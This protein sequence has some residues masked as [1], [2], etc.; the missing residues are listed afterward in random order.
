M[1]EAVARD[2][3]RAPGFWVD[4]LIRAAW[5][6]AGWIGPVQGSL[7]PKKEAEANLL[8][9]DRGIK[10]HEQVTRETSGGDWEENIE[11]LAR[12]N[13]ALAA[14]GGSRVTLI[15]S[16]PPQSEEE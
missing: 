12:E 5:C 13:A 15:Q 6:G 9:I 14:A 16:D 7:D 3:V 4:P 1:A 11:Q 8:L 10:T 2:R